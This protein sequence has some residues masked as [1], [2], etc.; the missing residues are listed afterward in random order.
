MDAAFQ[1]DVSTKLAAMEQR[2]NMSQSASTKIMREDFERL[3][4][5]LHFEIDSKMESK[6]EVTLAPIREKLES[7]EKI[8]HKVTEGMQNTETQFAKQDLQHQQQEQEQKQ[9]SQFQQQ[10]QYQQQQQHNSDIMQIL[11]QRLPPPNQNMQ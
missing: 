1:N 9:D 7:A 3:Q 4:T 6:L 11:L 10:Q 8:M 5:K 2:I